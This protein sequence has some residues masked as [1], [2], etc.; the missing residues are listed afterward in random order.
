MAFLESDQSADQ[1]SANNQSNSDAVA[2]TRRTFTKLFNEE[3]PSISLSF[4]SQSVGSLEEASDRWQGNA[5]RR[6]CEYIVRY[7][8]IG[9][10]CL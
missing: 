6:D 10:S 4:F 7:V 9:R 2:L 8:L 1:R 5:R 3:P